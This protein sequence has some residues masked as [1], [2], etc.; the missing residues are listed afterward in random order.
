[1]SLDGTIKFTSH[2]S[3]IAPPS[4]PE[5]PRVL[6]PNSFPSF[7][8]ETIFLLFQLVLI[9]IIKSP[10]FARASTCLSKTLSYP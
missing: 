6:H 3:F 8:A 5:N 2:T 1:M 7:K 9:P 4:R 10:L